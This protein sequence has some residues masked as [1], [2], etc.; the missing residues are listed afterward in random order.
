[1][2]YKITHKQHCSN[3][4]LKT[5]SHSFINQ[6]LIPICAFFLHFLPPPPT[7]FSF[8]KDY[9][10]EKLIRAL[11]SD[12]V[13]IVLGDANYSSLF[14]DSAVI[15]AE[16]FESPKELA[17]YLQSLIM[18]GALYERHLSWKYPGQRIWQIP[19]LAERKH[20]GRMC[21]LCELLHRPAEK[22]IQKTYSSVKRW[23]FDGQCRGRPIPPIRPKYVE[24]KTYHIAPRRNQR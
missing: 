15:N 23:W 13:P 12:V 20:T 9:V 3:S 10:T 2:L 16:H 8:C 11:N 24:N 5:I 7:R 18:D 1:M 19:G 4:I 21:K 17:K 6:I 22:R 14:P